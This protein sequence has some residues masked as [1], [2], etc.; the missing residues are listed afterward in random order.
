MHRQPAAGSWGSNVKNTAMTTWRRAGAAAL[1]AGSLTSG[2]I[3]QERGTREEA[4]AMV[5]AAVEH[6]RKV[7]PDAAF[8]DFSDRHNAAWHVKDLYVF[9]YT[10]D[11][12]N[13][14]HGANPKLIGKNLIDM[15][16]PNG[17]LLIRDLRDT[18]LKG[19]GWVEYEWPHP[20]SRK[21]EA[22]VS[23]VRKTL[24]YDGFVGVGAYR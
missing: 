19:G 17:R 22:K 14:G 2:A 18:A 10:L 7:G 1:L 9:A 5:E 24:N 13:V 3:A 23:Y 11:G 12:V 15:K 16:D 6:V 4:R 20:Q 21:V 8:G